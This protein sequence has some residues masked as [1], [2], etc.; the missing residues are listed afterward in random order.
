MSFRYSMDR[1][2]SSRSHGQSHCSYDLRQK[3]LRALY[4]C[5]TGPGG[6]VHRCPPEMV[7]LGS[8]GIDLFWR[9]FVE[10]ICGVN[11]GRYCRFK[12]KADVSMLSGDC[13]CLEYCSQYQMSFRN[14]A[15][16]GEKLITR[17]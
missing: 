1:D 7:G 17:Q 16:L 6:E 10:P 8:Q 15:S 4:D 3:G 12:S 2:V 13:F 9:T 14:P 5:Y 11:V